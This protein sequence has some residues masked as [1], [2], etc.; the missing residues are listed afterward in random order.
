[1]MKLSKDF[2]WGGAIADFQAEG[3][4]QEG[5]RGLSTHD[6]ESA[7]SVSTPR[8]NTLRMPDGS[9]AT[10]KSHFF[11]PES[12]PEGAEPYIFPERYYPSHKAVDFYHHFREDI[13]LMAGMGYNVFRFSICW[14][15]IYPT[16]LE[17]Q[18]NE[19]GLRFYEQVLDELEKYGMEPLITIHHDE[20]PA[21]LAKAY[22]GWSGRQ[23]IDCYLRYCRT[24]FERFG[25]RCRY[26]LTFNEINAVRGFAACGTRKA[27]DQTHYNAVHNMFLAS[28]R[29][30]QL[31]HQM[32]PGSMFG[33]M[34]ALSEIYPATCKPEDVFRRM[35]CRR[36]SWYFADVMARG[37][38]PAYAADL[39][40][41][42]GVTLHTQP[43][44]DEILK[45]GALDFVSFSYYRSCTI[46]A[47]TKFNVVG[48]DANPY[49]PSTPWGWPIDPLGLRYC[50]NEVYDRYQKP[51]FIVE[52]GLG[53][54]DQVEAD[55]TIQDDY[56]I[57]YLRD[58]LRAMMEAI[59]IDG[60]PCLGY[61]MWGPFD[62]VSLSTGEMKKRYGVIYVDMDDAG[63]GTLERKPKKS[64]YW[65]KE[66]IGTQGESLWKE[67]NGQ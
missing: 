45:A 39:L 3:G 44:D 4:Y 52:N 16:G 47:D 28:A 55:G 59:L 21:G 34:Y 20:L 61:T 11:G 38:Y 58:H 22:D 46:S 5:G 54:I 57:D 33:A 23:T 6:F 53:A 31:G 56:R 25:K 40:R 27:D 24:L 26:W 7:G 62:L 48:G 50:M 51:I 32:M 1:M 35:Q 19:E 29:A 65:M 66:V 63:N 36:E 9:C 42:R 30:V 17:T 41:R 43:G 14:S 12:L 60:V 10:A 37:A 8:C 49:L 13:A 64:Y 15:R 18:P 67:E 2:L